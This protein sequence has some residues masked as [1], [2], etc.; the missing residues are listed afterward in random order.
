MFACELGT[1]R[2]PTLLSDSVNIHV[3]L[4]PSGFLVPCGYLPEYL[5]EC[6]LLS[7]MSARGPTLAGAQEVLAGYA[8]L[9]LCVVWGRTCI[10]WTNLSALVK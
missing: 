4:Q 10:G 2:F 6:S 9:L 8:A 5:C 7:V 1:F 3:P